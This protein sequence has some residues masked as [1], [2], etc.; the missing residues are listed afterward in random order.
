MTS[1]SVVI[2]VDPEKC[3]NCHACIAVCPV[4]MCNDASGDH[5]VINH[6]SCIA[7]GRCI[8]ACTHDARYL[9]DD[10]DRF[11]EDSRKYPFVAISAPSVAAQFTGSYLQV[12]GFFKKFGV[13]DFFDVSFGAELTVKSYLEYQKSEKPSCIIAQPCPAIVNYIQMYVPELIP[14]LAPADSPMMHTVKMIHEYYP[15]YRDHKIVVISPCPAK[16]HEFEL[17]GLGD[18]LYN[19]TFKSIADYLAKNRID[20]T[21]FEEV[22]FSGPRA[23]RAAGFSTPGGL[24]QTAERDFTGISYLTRKIEGDSVF[25]YLKR[26]PAMI[27]S[28]RA[29]LLIDILNCEAGCN[30]GPGTTT[31]ERHTEEVE[32]PVRERVDSL[33]RILKA[34][35]DREAARK[36]GSLMRRYWK[37]NLYTRTYEN[38]GANIALKIPTE[39]QLQEIY[40]KMGK[41]ERSDFLDCGAC[42]YGSCRKMAIAVFNGLNRSEN[43]S[44]YK[45][46]LLNIEKDY[47]ENEHE[48]V[49]I[50]VEQLDVQNQK[51][52]RLDEER[53]RIAEQLTASAK[54]VEETN[55]HIATMTSDLATIA[56]EQESL[57]SEFIT[58]LG[59][60]ETIS[61]QFSPIAESISDIAEQ[62]DMLALNATIEAARAGDVGKGFAVVSDEVKKLSENTQLEVAKINPFAGRLSDVVDQMNGSAA[63]LFDKFKKMSELTR[64]VTTATEEMASSTSQVYSEIKKLAEDGSD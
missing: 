3:L 39:E 37:K 51:I 2:E 52:R 44:L 8:H 17:V 43:C 5:V 18:T 4:K 61:R 38:M 23:E 56:T 7:C 60:I 20:L 22:D 12:N 21:K 64:E 1:R 49:K 26:L 33:K 46:Q 50:Y 47:A 29:P 25:E 58:T 13:K 45:T 19:V 57:M 24:M 14:H 6:D 11:L 55:Y 32:H 35:D 31:H 59:D 41:R 62:T 10:F 36:M 42:G 40:G 34:K 9:K 16:K 15:K 48:K 28:G 53:R 27:A 30:G 63:V 54:E